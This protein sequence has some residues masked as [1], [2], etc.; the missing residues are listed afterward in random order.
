MSPSEVWHVNGADDSA[1]GEAAHSRAPPRRVRDRHLRVAAA[2]TDDKRELELFSHDPPRR[3]DL[4]GS[5]PAGERLERAED[6][7]DAE[8]WGQTTGVH[9]IRGLRAAKIGAREVACTRFCW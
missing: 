5:H 1:E 2:R 7:G 3:V 8:L 6:G 4:S 9:R